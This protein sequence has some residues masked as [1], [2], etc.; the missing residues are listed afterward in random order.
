MAFLRRKAIYGGVI[1]GQ[2]KWLFLGGFAWGFHWLGRIFAGGEP[3]VRYTREV[4]AG[5][6]VFVVHEPVGAV[7]AK[8]IARKQAK[9]ERKAAKR[10][11]KR[12]AKDA[13][14]SR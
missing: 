14:T 10:E 3:T 7:T 11:R 2:R 8:K 12:A 1:G 9:A 4:A 5:E 13:A 6:R